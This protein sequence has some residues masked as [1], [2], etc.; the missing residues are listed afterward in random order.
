MVDAVIDFLFLCSKITEDCD[1]SYEIIIRLLLG[2]KAV[3]NLD[4]VLKSR[5]YSADK[6]HIVQALVFP[7]VMC[8]CEG[9]TLRKVEH[10]GIDAFE[11]CWRRHLKVP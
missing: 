10:R 4:S 11:L 5:H 8:S 1:C 2:R 9:R 7:V 6:V 3:T